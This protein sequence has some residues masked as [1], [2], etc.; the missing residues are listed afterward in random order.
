MRS[1]IKRDLLGRR[2]IVTGP[3]GAKTR[4]TYD[5][6]NRLT[7]IA[8]PLGRTGRFQIWSQQ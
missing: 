8:D 3:R 1:T 4:F 6:L 2:V 7:A 5:L